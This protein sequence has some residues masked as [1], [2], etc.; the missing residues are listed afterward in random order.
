M[1][2]QNPFCH[3]AKMQVSVSQMSN[4]SVKNT[5]WERTATRKVLVDTVFKLLMLTP[6]MF[7]W[8]VNTA[9]S[10]GGAGWSK[11][12]GF[13]REHASVVRA[14][15]ALH[16][17]IPTAHL[18]AGVG[19]DHPHNGSVSYP[20]RPVQLQTDGQNRQMTNLQ[21]ETKNVPIDQ[22]W[23]TLLKYVVA[24]QLTVIT[25][26]RQKLE[27]HMTQQTGMHGFTPSVCLYRRQNVCRKNKLDTYLWPYTSWL[28]GLL[29]HEIWIT[30]WFHD[31]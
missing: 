1:W 2:E 5:V 3:F 13:G 14:C 28:L 27:H 26:A 4:Y 17:A 31:I 21:D 18:G 7:N 15:F 20:M 16:H 10:F 12:E 23:S 29:L 11:K 19:G 6:V 24:E 25:A 9:I 22:L 8:D 30:F